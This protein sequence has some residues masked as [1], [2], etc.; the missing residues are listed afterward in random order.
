MMENADGYHKSL[1]TAMNADAVANHF[2]QQ[3]KA[4]AVSEIT[5]DSKN[6]NMDPRKTDTSSVDTG[7]VKYKVISGDI[8]SGNFFDQFG[9][10]PHPSQC[11][12]LVETI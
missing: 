7:G 4:D 2:Y 12:K 3:G 10:G 6:I 11:H 9:P 8:T 1:F 5:K